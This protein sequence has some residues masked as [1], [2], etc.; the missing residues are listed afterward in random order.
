MS[1]NDG[2]K[3]LTIYSPFSFTSLGEYC[4]ESTAFVKPG[5]ASVRFFESLCNVWPSVTISI[6]S[7]K[8][9]VK[10]VLCSCIVCTENQERITWGTAG[11]HIP[12]YLDDQLTDRFLRMTLLVWVKQ[13]YLMCFQVQIKKVIMVSS[14]FWIIFKGQIKNQSLCLSLF[15]FY[16]FKF[17]FHCII[18]NASII[19]SITTHH[20][21]FFIF[22]HYFVVKI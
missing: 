14:K 13:M 19:W 9:L 21:S 11:Q 15:N 10:R 12:I 5:Y 3:S 1:W 20:F 6:V 7:V 8:D 2:T 16:A 4:R 22:L 18:I 17:S